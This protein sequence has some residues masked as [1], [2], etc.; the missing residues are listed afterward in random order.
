MFSQEK[1]KK[2][3]KKV[4]NTKTRNKVKTKRIH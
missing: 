3:R 2:K 4:V 1:Y